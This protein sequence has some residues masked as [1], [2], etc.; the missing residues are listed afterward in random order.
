MY[1][2]IVHAAVQLLAPAHSTNCLYTCMLQVHVYV[3]CAE[4]LHVYMFVHVCTCMFSRGI[5]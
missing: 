4:K 2:Y 5:H 1:M 3:Q